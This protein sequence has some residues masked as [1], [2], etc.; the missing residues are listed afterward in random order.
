MCGLQLPSDGIASVGFRGRVVDQDQSSVWP[1]GTCLGIRDGK[2]TEVPVQCA[3][4]HALEITGAID[5]S[6]VFDTGGAVDRRPGRG[7]AGCV[8]CG[9]VGVL[10][11]GGFGRDGPDPAL[12]ADRGERLGCGQPP[13][14]MSHRVGKTR[15]W[16]GDTGRHGQDRWSSSTGNRSRRCPARPRRCPARQNHPPLKRRRRS[17]RHS[18]RRRPSRRR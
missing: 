5:L 9:D 4:P 11:A 14:R 15:W 3:L 16:L 10:V 12:S 8:R 7:G 6:T 13:D 2:A 18:S 1:A 17:S